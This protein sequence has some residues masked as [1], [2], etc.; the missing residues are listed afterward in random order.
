MSELFEK[1]QALCM[2]K[3][4]PLHQMKDGCWAAT[5]SGGRRRYVVGYLHSGAVFV[6]EFAE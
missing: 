5:N 6:E 1:A 4:Y 2:V 3:L